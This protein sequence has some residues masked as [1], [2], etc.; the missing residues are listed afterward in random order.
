MAA[1]AQLPELPPLQPG[2]PPNRLAKLPISQLK[3]AKLKQVLRAAFEGKN[4]PHQLN[5]EGR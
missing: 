2:N 4:A 5:D 1:A 3:L